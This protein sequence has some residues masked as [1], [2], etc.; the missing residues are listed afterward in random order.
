MPLHIGKLEGQKASSLTF[1]LRKPFGAERK[2]VRDLT[3]GLDGES[4]EVFTGSK[5]L[6]VRRR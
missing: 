1:V 4:V 6:Q 2:T 5:K 3:L